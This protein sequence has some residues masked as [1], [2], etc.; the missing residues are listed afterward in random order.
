MATFSTVSLDE[1]RRAVLP[2]RRATQAQHQEYVRGLTAD[3]AGQLELGPEDRPITERAR[4]KAAAKALGKNLEIR[5]RGNTMVFWETNEP[6]K[7]RAKSTGAE[8]GR[9]KRR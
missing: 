9:G 3:A 6:P 1:A 5:R 4:L 2:P 7:T 8:Q